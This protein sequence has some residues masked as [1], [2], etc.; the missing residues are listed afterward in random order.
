MAFLQPSDV[1]DRRI[2]SGFDTAV[3]AVDRL[4]AADLGILKAVGFLLGRE[5]L[6]I[7]AQRALVTLERKNVIGLLIHDFLGDIA[8][9]AHRIDGHDGALDRH[10]VEQRRDWRRSRSTCPPL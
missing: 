9:A 2:G 8:L 7:L 5:K 3:I 1:M 4:M 10:H 6:D